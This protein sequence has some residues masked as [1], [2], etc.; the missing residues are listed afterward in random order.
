M[1][2]A[3]GEGHHPSAEVR[4]PPE[5]THDRKK[6]VLEL[7]GRNEGFLQI[8]DPTNRVV[9][10]L[11]GGRWPSVVANRPRRRSSELLVVE[12]RPAA[13]RRPHTQGS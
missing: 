3:I 10:G 2:L 12:C 4:R 6:H 13:S 11:E 5:V 7:L 1:S 8:V 9:R